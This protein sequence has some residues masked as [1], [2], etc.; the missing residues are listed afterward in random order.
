MEGGKNGFEEVPKEISVFLE[1]KNR[2]EMGFCTQIRNSGWVLP[3]WT[4]KRLIGLG[5]KITCIKHKAEKKWTK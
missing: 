1:N 5:R 2:E 4:E 3:G